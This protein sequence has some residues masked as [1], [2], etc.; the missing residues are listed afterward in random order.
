MK[1][2][3]FKNNIQVLEGMTSKPQSLET[4]VQLSKELV[5]D[6]NLGVNEKW[7]TEMYDFYNFN[8]YHIS[9]QLDIEKGLVSAE[10]KLNKELKVVLGEYKTLTGWVGYPA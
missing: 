2:Q 1:K 3:E 6:S 8:P 5:Y 7:L 9:Y 4:L 10:T